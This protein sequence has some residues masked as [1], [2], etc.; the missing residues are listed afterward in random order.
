MNQTEKIMVF[1]ASTLQISLIKTAKALGF[2][3]IALDPD[4]QAI[5]KSIADEFIVVKG[6]DFEKSMQIAIEH[7]VKGIVTTATDKPILMM[8]RLA[9]ELDLPFPS[10]ESCETVLDKAKF[11]QFLFNNSLPHAKGN[12]YVGMIDPSSLTI[13]YP[14]IVK[15]AMN[16]GSRGVLK[17]VNAEDLMVVI[18]E[19]LQYCKDDIYLIEEFIEGDEISVEVLVQDNK[20][21][22]LQITDK[23]VTPPPYNVELGH[24]QPSRYLY[25]KDKITDLIQTIVDKTGLNNCALHPELKIKND[26]IT[27][28]EIGPRLGGDFITSHLVPLSTGV[29]MEDQLI[30]I[31]TGLKVEFNIISRASM[32]SYLNFP[33]GFK[34]ARLFSENDLK[35]I[36]PEIES[37]QFN[38]K[39]GDETKQITNS[40]NRYGQ[41]LLAGENANSLNSQKEIIDKFIIQ[42][43]E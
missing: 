19:T 12:K 41:F 27:I 20:V 17:C 5:G 14:V 4:P 28:I 43:I 23:I 42:L 16:S 7:K 36:F 40:L 31:A 25:L 34:I 10:Y 38:L 11:K 37:F 32:V 3:T 22:M 6:D 18:K 39:I 13:N 8:C 24:I 35:K 2:Y 9:R 26:T 33:V 29:N 1:G 30:R 21:H 15:P